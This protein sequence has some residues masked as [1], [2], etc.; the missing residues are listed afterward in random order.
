MAKYSIGLII[1]NKTAVYSDGLYYGAK[2]ALADTDCELVVLSALMQQFGPVDDEYMSIAFQNA[3]NLNLDAYIVSAGTITVFLQSYGKNA[4]DFLKYL[5]KEKTI[6]IEDKI[7]GYHCIYKDNKPGIRKIMHYLIET[8]E[9]KKIAFISGPRKSF[10][11]KER[12]E[13]FFEEM[14]AHGLETNDASF[15]YGDFLGKCYKEIDDIVSRNPGLEALVCAND[16]I[17]VTAFDVL[18]AHGLEPGRDVAVTG[19]DDFPDA[20]FSTPT[21]TTVR[22]SSH[23]MGYTAA[24]RTADFLEFAITPDD[25]IS[26]S[27][28]I[29][30]STGGSL[31]SQNKVYLKMISRRPW[32]IDEITGEIMKHCTSEYIVDSDNV[33]YRKILKMVSN[34]TKIYDTGYTVSPFINFTDISTLEARESDFRIDN[35]Q[36]Q[37]NAFLK[38]LV[39]DDTGAKRERAIKLLLDFNIGVTAGLNSRSRKTDREF[40]EQSYLMSRM[41]GSA[42]LANMSETAAYSSMFERM[43]DLG[44]SKAEILLFEEPVNYSKDDEIY[45]PH[46][47]FRKAAYGDNGIYV[48]EDDGENVHYESIMRNFMRRAPIDEKVC[49]VMGL[50]DSHQLI[51]LLI[52]GFGSSD[53]T[54]FYYASLQVTYALRHIEISNSEKELIALLNHSNNRL[55]A[56]VSQDPLTGL[57]NR[58][59]F[60]DAVSALFKSSPNRKCAIFYMDMDYFKDINDNFGHDE[61]DRAIRCMSIILQNTFT[62]NDSVISRYG[63]DEFVAFSFVDEGESAEDIRARLADE[64]EKFNAS[65]FKAYRLAISAGAAVFESRPDADLKKILGEADSLLYKEKK[66][67]HSSE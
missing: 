12:A 15:T 60:K 39:S 37:M 11:A 10:G 65:R 46:R 30:R 53:M 28:V 67:H 42:L 35:F 31:G 14:E 16:L 57:L 1:E 5:P 52:A 6:V 27:L 32:P 40:R 26:G 3:A 49:G 18:R 23:K 55:L 8:L 58:R 9:L 61:G 13:A 41:A 63:G 2:A 22:L 21:L 29:R 45:I 62:G 66:R 4:N 64:V 48:A 38:A 44:F 59:G 25:S 43:I 51:G 33:F 54:A 24:R 36:E 50:Y 56:E 19:Y 7:E 17:A 20:A 47:L 34:I